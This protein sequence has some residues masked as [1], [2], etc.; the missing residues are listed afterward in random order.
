MYSNWGSCHI[1]M[2]VFTFRCSI[3]TSPW[4]RFRSRGKR[5]SHR[6]LSPR[7]RFSLPHPSFCPCLPFIQMCFFPASALI[8]SLIRSIALSGCRPRNLSRRQPLN[9][10]IEARFPICPSTWCVVSVDVTSLKR[11][12]PQT[13]HVVTT[14]PA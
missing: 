10:F 1:L 8:I 9:W 3:S 7:Y 5:R 6:T 4:L 2:N 12:M 13:Y 14:R 11:F